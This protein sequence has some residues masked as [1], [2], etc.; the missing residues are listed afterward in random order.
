M[1]KVTTINLNN[2]A[3]QIDEDGYDALRAYLDSA[4]RALADNPDREEIL[5]DLEQAIADKCL[6]TLGPHKNVVSAAEIGRILKEMGPVAGGAQGDTAGATGST[7][8]GGNT[9]PAAHGPPGF[10]QRRLY[11]I[12]EGQTWAGICNGLAAFAGVDV[13]LV[14]VAV[15]LITIFTGFFIGLLAYFVM[16]FVLP[17]A[18][19]PEEIAAAH[20]QPFRAQEVVDRVKKKHDD[21][22]S[23]Q[24]GKRRMRH[25]ARWSTQ[26]APP[27][28][29]YAA[30]VTGGILL[31]FLT[32]LS[33]VWFFAMAAVAYIVWQG[34][35]SL[36]FI[37]WP[38]GSWH[39][40]SDIP[41]WV[42]MIAIVAIYAVLAIPIGS[43]RRASLYYANGGRLHGWADAWSGLLWLALV[44]VLVL[45]TWYLLPQLE[46]L[47]RFQIRANPGVITL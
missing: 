19:T 13:T 16:I 38:P 23:E 31:P 4:A 21:W 47:L 8:P 46:D 17:V 36:G 5:C 11:R 20:G 25:A 27:A 24:R 12:A 26:P 37:G 45:G 30:R 10:R 9:A 32:V 28:P 40:Y 2:N 15:V 6:L 34:W 7:E 3:Y 43:A 39:G 18:T 44:A 41:R 42:A 14:R 29:G 33:A 22:R 1:R 35:Y